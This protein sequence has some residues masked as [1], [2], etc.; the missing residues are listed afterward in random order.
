MLLILP[1][2]MFL[3]PD[4]VNEAW[5]NF[6]YLLNPYYKDYPNIPIYE[7]YPPEESE[8]P[9]IISLDGQLL[10]DYIISAF[11]NPKFPHK[12]NPRIINGSVASMLGC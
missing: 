6:I 2:V 12:E 10:E 4:E 3:C 8:T 11:K 7:N 5:K 9:P 1:V